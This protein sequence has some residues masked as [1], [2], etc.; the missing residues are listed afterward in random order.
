MS[1]RLIVYY[2]LMKKQI[3]YLDNVPDINTNLLMGKQYNIIYLSS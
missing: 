3:F 1:A 2:L